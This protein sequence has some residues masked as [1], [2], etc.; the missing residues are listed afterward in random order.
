[1]MLVGV[2]VHEEG[3]AW[4]TPLSGGPADQPVF[5]VSPGRMGARDIEHRL[6]IG[7]GL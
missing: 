3:S 6:D 5:R 4:R 2:P 1:L 7:S